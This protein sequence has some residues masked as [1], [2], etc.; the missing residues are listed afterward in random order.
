MP[1][2]DAPLVEPR[3]ATFIEAETDASKRDAMACAVRTYRRHETLAVGDLVP[4]L[5][6]PRLDGGAPV[7]LAA[8]RGT[9]L[10]LIFGSYT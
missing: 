6:L 2:E 7:A 4:A 8:A 5:S 9:P 10:V 3:D 1:A